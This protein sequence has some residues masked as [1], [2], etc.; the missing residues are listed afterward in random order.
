L[1]IASYLY[2]QNRT[3]ITFFCVK[4]YGPRPLGFSV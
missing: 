3:R 2:Y 4:L 1:Q